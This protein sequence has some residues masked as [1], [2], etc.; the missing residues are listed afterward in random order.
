MKVKIKKP[1][2][3][4]GGVGLGGGESDSNQIENS[5]LQIQLGC[6]L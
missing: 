3:A 5:L 4:P 6:I 2:I 1:V